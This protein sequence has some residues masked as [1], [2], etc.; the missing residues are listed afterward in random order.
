MFSRVFS[1][2]VLCMFC[3]GPA[4]YGS[5]ARFD[6]SLCV[7]QPHTAPEVVLRDSRG[8]EKDRIPGWEL[9]SLATPALS[10]VVILRRG[11]EVKVVVPVTWPVTV[12]FMSIFIDGKPVEM[13]RKGDFRYV[14]ETMECAYELP[15]LPFGRHIVQAQY[16]VGK[17]WSRL[18]EPLHFELRE[19][20]SSGTDESPTPC[21]TRFLDGLGTV[22][23]EILS[24][25][26]KST[27]DTNTGGSHV[28]ASAAHLPLRGYGAQGEVYDRTGLVIYEGMKFTWES[29]GDYNLRF[30]A[31]APPMPVTLRLQLLIRN[32]ESG[33]EHRITLPP[34]EFKPRSSR[35][36]RQH[37][38]AIPGYSA[39]IDEADGHI[40]VIRRTGIARFGYGL[41]E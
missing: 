2:V 33:A 38:P 11:L 18:S 26:G 32:D 4:N 7:E 9:S 8:G 30:Q 13:K 10:P 34:I 21:A 12:S 31:E 19:T 16:L 15:S 17:R 14:N 3:W 23:D 39:A 22:C 41:G 20:E 35:E 36:G 27:V 29:N 28:F 25:F 6:C 5:A 1:F 40:R 37:D 24:S